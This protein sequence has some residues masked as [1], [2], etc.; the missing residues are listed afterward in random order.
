MTTFFILAALLYCLQCA[1]LIYGLRRGFKSGLSVFE[2]SVSIVMAARNEEA[3]IGA[4]LDSLLSVEYP[5]EKLEIVVVDDSSTD[6]TLE[7]M[8]LRLLGHPNCRIIQARQ[9]IDH[10]KG[11]A[12]AIAQG[13]DVAKGEIILM[14][15]ADCVVPT[16]WVKGTVEHYADNV[17]VVA[18]LTLLH[19]NG[20]F[21]GMQS[22]DWAYILAVA[23]AAM[24]L[25]KPLSCIGNNFSFRKRAYDDIGGYRKVPFSVTEDFALFKAMTGS[26]RWEYR[27]PLDRKTL[28]FSRACESMGALFRQK[29]RW[30]VGGKD[31]PLFGLSIMAIAFCFHALLLFGPFLRPPIALLATGVLVKFLLDGV[32]VAIPLKRT[33]QFSQFRYFLIFEIYFVVYVL[34]LPFSVFLGGRVH[35][36]GRSY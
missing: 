31:I 18:G 29:R 4:S 22:L 26:G 35:W 11:K 14:T 19:P 25:K 33:G 5:P 1:T 9:G 10:L 12:N 15:D 16:T 8:N 3:N 36:K 13:I 34:I 32:L 17:G 21:A 30:G 28:V 24:S 27:Y 7:L 20:W 6:R 23:S 2:P